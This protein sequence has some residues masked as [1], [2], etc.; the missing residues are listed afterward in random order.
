MLVVRLDTPE[1]RLP[2]RIVFA[3]FNISV[4]LLLLLNCC[5]PNSSRWWFG[6]KDDYC[7]FVFVKFPEMRT[8]ANCAIY[9]SEAPEH[10][11]AVPTSVVTRPA[12]N[13]AN[14]RTPTTATATTYNSSL[15][16]VSTSQRLWNRNNKR[17]EQNSGGENSS[18]DKIPVKFDLFSPD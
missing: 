12:S 14:A 7:K 18:C 15:P 10:L 3:P 5:M 2:W 13:N 11:P 6:I 9:V 8:F 1:M 16:V 4:L 17:D